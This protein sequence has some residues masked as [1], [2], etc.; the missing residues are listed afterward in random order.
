[1]ISTQ[2]P[3]FP[4]PIII[5]HSFIHRGYAINGEERHGLGVL[6]QQHS[7]RLRFEIGQQRAVDAVLQ[8][9]HSLLKLLRKHKIPTH[10]AHHARLR[11]TPFLRFHV[12]LHA[13]LR[14][15]RHDPLKQLGVSLSSAVPQQ[16]LVG[17]IVG[18]R[19]PQSLRRVV[20][21]LH[22]QIVVLL[23]VPQQQ[24]VD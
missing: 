14:R 19:F 13:L 16:K 3:R 21:E 17:Q 20:Q 7:K 22:R 9:L 11:L 24:R 5:I 8:Q 6:P 1:M 18:P 2:F 23:H 10:F 15:V 12:I 4:S